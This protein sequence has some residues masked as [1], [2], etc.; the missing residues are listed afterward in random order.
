MT[1]LN[2]GTPNLDTKTLAIF[3]TKKNYEIFCEHWRRLCGRLN[4]SGANGAQKEEK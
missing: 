1:M 4:P 3:G 2:I